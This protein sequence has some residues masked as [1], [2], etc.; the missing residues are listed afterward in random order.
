[1][2][3]SAQSKEEE[4]KCNILEAARSLFGKFG[5]KKT[6]MEEIADECG[7]G[8]STLYHYF[9]NKDEIFLS[10]LEMECKQFQGTIREAV[11]KEVGLASKLRALLQTKLQMIQEFHVFF[12]FSKDLFLANF[13]R[14]R[15]A[16]SSYEAFEVRLLDQLITEAVETKEIQFADDRER[17]IKTY[18][19]AIALKGIYMQAMFEEKFDEFSGKIEGIVQFL[20][21]GLKSE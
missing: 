18:G 14:F 19:L 1:M 16:M 6:S 11:E 10:V 21:Q 8:K 20:H 7:K 4:I 13:D 5:L 9:K 3:Y 2:L 17:E 12:N 15:S